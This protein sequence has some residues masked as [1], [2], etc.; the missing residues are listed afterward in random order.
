MKH[1]KIGNFLRSHYSRPNILALPFDLWYELK[2]FI[3][4]GRYGWDESDCWNFDYYL[5]T[6]VIDALR[7]T[8][9]HGKAYPAETTHEAW[10]KELTDIA[11]SIEH[12]RVLEAEADWFHGV[13]FQEALNDE[14]E[15]EKQAQEARKRFAE[16]WKEM[17]W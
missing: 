7:H 4:R 1:S 11:D 2:A 9:K 16:V 17:W 13:D 10:K 15:A 12:Y 5:D 14:V 6:V 8:V 3:H